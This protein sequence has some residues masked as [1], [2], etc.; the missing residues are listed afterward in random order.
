MRQDARLAVLRLPRR[1]ASRRSLWTSMQADDGSVWYFGE[2]VYNYR[3]GVV[4]DISGT[5]LAGKEGPAAM[6]MPADPAVGVVHRPENIPGLVWEEV[7]VKAVGQQADGPR[8]PVTGAMIGRELRAARSRADGASTQPADGPQRGPRRAP[9]GTR[10][11]APVPPSGRDRPPPLRPLGSTGRRRR[12]P[13][14]PRGGRRRRGHARVDSRPDS[15]HARRCLGDAHR[16]EA[17]AATRR[18]GR[19][20]A[21]LGREGPR[22]RCAGCSPA[23][24]LAYERT[25]AARTLGRH[26]AVLVLAA[27]GARLDGVLE[28]R[29]QHVEA[30]AHGLRI[31]GQVD[32]ERRAELAGDGA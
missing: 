31:A 10:P 7:A 9:G 28:H 13:A 17:G 2:D 15:A 12:S 20:Q 25:R 8:G 18:R 6:I 29:Q 22:R 3:H 23:P 14:P 26:L 1:G 11:Q 24:A 5:W 30:L 21:G 32:H 16:H 4:A 27:A 19:R